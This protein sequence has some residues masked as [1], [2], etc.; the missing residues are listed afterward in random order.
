VNALI[1]G[2]AHKAIEG[3]VIVIPG[4]LCTWTSGLSITV[5]ITL[6]GSGSPNADGG[7]FGAGTL[8]TIITDNVGSSVPL[9]KITGI[10]FGQT[11]VLSLLDIEPQSSTTSLTSPIQIAGTCSANGCPSIR[12]DNI[13]FGLGIPWTQ[14]GNGGGVSWLIRTD[15]VFGVIDHCTVAPGTQADFFDVNHSAYLGVGV[16]G[17]NSWAQPDTIGGANNLYAE[18][19][20]IYTNTAV[21]DC[22][23]APSGGSVGG[24]RYVARFNR[25][26]SS[27]GFGVFGNHGTETDGRPRGGRQIEVYGNTASCT[28]SS[29][30]V[31]AGYRSG[32]GVVFGNTLTSSTGTWFNAFVA[33]SVYRTVFAAGGGWGA[34]GG[35]GPYDL[36]DGVVYYSG[37]NSG[38]DGSTTLTDPTKNW[39]T[40]QFVPPGFPYSVYDLTKGWWAEIA[41]NTTTALTIRSSIPEQANT[42]NHGD[43]YQI[44]RAAVCIDQ[45]GHGAG[46]YLSGI[47]ASLAG[48]P[49][50]SLDPV[51]EWD[52]TASLLG[53]TNVTTDTLRTVANRDWYTDGSNG[54]PR[55][56]TSATFPFDGSSGVGWGTTANRPMTCT[57]GVGYWATDQ[58][59]WNTSGNGFGN[60]V[61]YR[62][63][64]PNTWTAY[65]TPYPYPH[66]LVGGIKLSGVAP[67]TNL[68]I[69]VH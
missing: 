24:C 18:N 31:L 55:Q 22:E 40:N 67:P 27:N 28:K 44:L 12:I 10:S 35:S 32:T 38:S 19:N 36:N 61:L 63:S 29:C 60:G 57:L 46:R 25:I 42:F 13:A 48:W 30:N 21:S 7:T 66:P 52:N 11:I 33:I 14:N 26:T 2:P 6:T 34:C 43:S 47:P 54:R 9:I 23:I 17:D 62:C 53:Q 49:S 65:Y 5:G 3:D 41:S 45:V 20:V 50:Q 37:A 15:N 8:T 64:A 56:Q 16:Y 51:Y 1:N 58:G 68:M 59:S 4:G 39:S 69:T